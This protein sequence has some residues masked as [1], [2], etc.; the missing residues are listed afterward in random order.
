MMAE[1]ISIGNDDFVTEDYLVRDV[2]P[3]VFAGGMFAKRS[4]SPGESTVIPNTAIKNNTE[5]FV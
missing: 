1:K 2:L 3:G 5:E 4:K